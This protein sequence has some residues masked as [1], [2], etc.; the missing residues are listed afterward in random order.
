MILI[1]SQD[2]N[3]PSTDSIIDWL[4]MYKKP[5]KRFNGIDFYKK[6]SISIQDGA[7]KIQLPNVDLEHTNLI[8]LRRWVTRDNSKDI[9]IKNPQNKDRVITQINEYTKSELKVLLDFF[10]KSIPDDLLFS[11]IRTEEINKL[12]VLKKARELGLPIP[13]THILTKKSEY[14][15]LVKKG[16]LITKAISNG[17]TVDVDNEKFVGYTATVELLPEIMNESFSPSLFQSKIE[18]KYEIRS[19]YLSGKFYSMAIFS[20][21]DHQTEVDFRRYNDKAPN[22]TVPYQLPKEIEVK[23]AQLAQSFG[24]NTGSFD[25]IKTIDNDYVFLEVNPGG[26]FEMVSKPCN[27][28]LEKRIAI[29]LIKSSEQNENNRSFT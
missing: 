8:W 20:Q 25:L 16:N 1:F 4:D 6:V 11:S 19:F 9:F 23:L 26:Q 3:E 12:L 27:Y 2:K 5:F 18:K 24:L 17:A 10:F 7:F 29:E 21:G 15:K 22:R 14:D 28:N 13:E